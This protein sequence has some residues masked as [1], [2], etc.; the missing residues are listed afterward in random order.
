MLGTTSRSPPSNSGASLLYFKGNF[1]ICRGT[2]MYW[3]SWH[4]VTLATTIWQDTVIFWCQYS[5]QNNIVYQV[6][7]GYHELGG[8]WKL[9]RSND[10][11]TLL[12]S[13]PICWLQ[14]EILFSP[15]QTCMSSDE[16]LWSQARAE[17]KTWLSGSP[18]TRAWNFCGVGTLLLII[19]YCSIYNTSQNLWYLLLLISWFL[20]ESG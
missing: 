18:S 17:L 10:S 16:I 3:K 2:A 11:W 13:P 12:N 20:S 9:S 7:V 14:R 19:P 5:T 4:D 1:R 8:D 6:F 15:M